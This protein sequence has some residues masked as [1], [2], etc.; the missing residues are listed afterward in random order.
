[1]IKNRIVRAVDSGNIQR[2]P[3]F[4]AIFNYYYSSSDQLPSGVVFD[5]AGIDV[6]KVRP[7]F[8]PK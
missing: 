7:A 8:R 2:S 4:Q 5:S 6:E 3:T 1:M